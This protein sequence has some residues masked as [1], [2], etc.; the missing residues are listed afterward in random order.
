MY[1]RSRCAQQAFV[2]DRLSPLE[3]S[4]AGFDSEFDTDESIPARNGWWKSIFGDNRGDQVT[5]IRPLTFENGASKKWM[6]ALTAFP[7]L[8]ELIIHDTIVEDL[9]FV[10]LAD[11]DALE[12]LDLAKTNISDADLSSIRD[13]KKLA[14]LDLRKTQIGNAGSK[15]LADLT[16]LKT[17]HLQQTQIGDE[18]VQHLSNLKNLEHLDLSDTNVSEKSIDILAQFTKLKLLALNPETFSFDARD[19]L[20]KRL[21]NC[22]IIFA[23]N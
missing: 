20:R 12:K 2:H 8:Q 3:P 4:Y 6:R 23:K 10:N 9:G 19:K 18:G 1:E 21:P 22:D 16:N 13:L 5:C 14:Y 17:L 11:L 7:H 15:H